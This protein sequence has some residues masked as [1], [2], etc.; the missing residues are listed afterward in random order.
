M[1]ERWLR[2]AAPAIAMALTAI[3]VAMGSQTTEPAGSGSASEPGRSEAKANGGASMPVADAAPK[4]PGEGMKLVPLGHQPLC[5]SSAAIAAP[6][7]PATAF[8][9]DNETS[10]ALFAFK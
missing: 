8:V 1:T 5:E 6:W 3:L 7:D 4:R 9:A 2:I 10:E